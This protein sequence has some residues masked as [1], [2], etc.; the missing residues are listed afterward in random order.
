MTHQQYLNL[1]QALENL[2][3]ALSELSSSTREYVRQEHRPF[4]STRFRLFDEYLVTRRPEGF[5]QFIRLLPNEFEDLYE[6]IGSRLEH[7]LCHA[8]PIVGRHRLMIYLR[9]V[10]Q[11]MS[12]SAFAL[13]MGLGIETVSQVVEEVT[14]AIISG[15][16]NDAFP[17]LTLE[18]LEE[19]A[20][21]TQERYDYPRSVG[22]MDGKH[23]N[24]RKP[25]HSGSSFWN[26]LSYYSIVLLAVCDCDYRI[27]I[28]DV[29]SPGCNGDAGVYRSSSIKRFLDENDAI[30]PPTRELGT[31]GP[32]Q[33]HFLVDGGFGQSHRFV[34]PYR[35][36]EANTPDRK[37]F[38]NKMCRA[39]RL[40]ESTFGLLAQRFQILM[41]RIELEPIRAE[42]IVISVMILHNLL[43]RRE[44]SLA[45][46]R[47]H[48]PAPDGYHPLQ[49]DEEEAG[50]DSPNIAKDRITQHY[51]NL[52][53]HA[54]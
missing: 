40:I 48:N 47:R 49:I 17:P 22:F 4:L 54:A 45:G 16:H 33:Y 18:M 6:K 35:E 11:G 13:D 23:I 46:V 32:V 21:K 53:G 19:V 14:E 10:T 42:R 50:R 5:L 3:G 51:V 43:P 39:R 15:L 28:Y 37:R 26:Y 8:G 2:A 36:R 29:G 12:F 9:I 38:N 27:I 41:N 34:R 20:R 31:V 30:F 44:D 7:A 25:A 1:H 52:Y 24:I